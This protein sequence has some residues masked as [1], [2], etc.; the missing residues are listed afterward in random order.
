MNTDDTFGPKEVVVGIEDGDNAL[1]VH[2]DDIREAGVLN[3]QLGE[4][5]VVLIYDPEIDAALAWEAGDKTFTFNGE[6]AVDQNGVE[7][8]VWG[9]GSNGDSLE[10]V[11]SFDAMWF[12]WVAFYP[13][14][15]IHGV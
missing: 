4:R 2:K 10:F 3:L 8:D 13:E 1:A 12:S 5:N 9:Q 7:W 6:K 15:E 14:T 11:G